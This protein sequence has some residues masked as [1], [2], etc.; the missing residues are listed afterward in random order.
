MNVSSIGTRAW[1]S[2]RFACTSPHARRSARTAPAPHAG[3]PSPRT[4]PYSLVIANAYTSAFWL[5]W[6]SAHTSGARC[7]AVPCGRV[8]TCVASTP[9]TRDRPKSH[10]LAHSC[11][12]RP[13][14]PAPPVVAPVAGPRLP[15]PCVPGP[16]PVP[17]P[18]AGPGA[19]ALV[20]ADLLS[21]AAA[22]LS[23]REAAPC[24][25]A[26]AAAEAAAAEAP[27]AGPRELLRE[28][29]SGVGAP[30]AE[31]SREK[32]VEVPVDV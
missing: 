32:D 30:E 8:D 26:A 20:G 4:R 17:R 15:P 23:R 11:S 27:A 16:V 3:P 18:A 29:A 31:A 12:E 14:P 22:G 24:A 6:P 1:T 25:G 9:S 21:P 19:T 10:T 13:A 28:A 7:V 2:V 5:T